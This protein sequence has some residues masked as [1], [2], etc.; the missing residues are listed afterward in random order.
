MFCAQACH[1]DFSECF[2]VSKIVFCEFVLFLELFMKKFTALFCSICAFLFFDARSL[3]AQCLPLSSLLALGNTPITQSPSSA[4]ARYLPAIEW[5]YRGSVDGGKDPYWTFAPQGSTAASSDDAAPAWIS[6]RANQGK[7]D[8]VF[9]T[10]M[11]S[12][13]NQLK[14]ELRALKIKT[15]PITCVE[16]EGIRYVGDGYTVNI[17]SKKKGAFPNVVVVHYGTIGTGQTR[18]AAGSLSIGQ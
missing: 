2:I 4:V 13:V 10:P 5:A 18:D 6:L 8:V 1:S 3:Q 16:C 7:Y 11:G 9:K 14:S 15:E 12:C 17:Y